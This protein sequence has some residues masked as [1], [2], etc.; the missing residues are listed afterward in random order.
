MYG[1]HKRRCDRSGRDRVNPGIIIKRRNGQ[2]GAPPITHLVGNKQFNNV[3]R[4]WWIL[5]ATRGPIPAG[6]PEGLPKSI[7]RSLRSLHWISPTRSVIG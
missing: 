7:Q 6:N 1:K 3:D 4:D 2:R 5:L